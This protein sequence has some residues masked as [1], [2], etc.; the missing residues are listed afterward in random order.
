MDI[1][2]TVVQVIYVGIC[3]AIVVLVLKQEG[4]SSGLSGAITGSADNSYWNKIRGRS[5]EGM[6]DNATKILGTLF[7]VLSLVLDIF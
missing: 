7:I 5:K 3:V 1:L 4:D 6:L 2:K